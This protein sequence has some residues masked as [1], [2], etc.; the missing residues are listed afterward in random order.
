MP[1]KE[2]L[3]FMMPR[4][5]QAEIWNFSG[6]KISRSDSSRTNHGFVAGKADGIFPRSCPMDSQA[7]LFDGEGGI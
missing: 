6:R 1:G 2:N 3:I 5:F 4:K 7:Q